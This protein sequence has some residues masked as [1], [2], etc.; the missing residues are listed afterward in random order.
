MRSKII[1]KA[2]NLFGR[3]GGFD[4]ICNLLEQASRGEITVTLPQIFSYVIFMYNTSPLWHRQFLCSFVDRLNNAILS[5]LS[6]VNTEANDS[7]KK[8]L[9]IGP[10]QVDTF[11][12]KMLEN[13]INIYVQPIW[14][15][16]NTKEM[17]NKILGYYQLE[18]GTALLKL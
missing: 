11:D 16:Y 5:S 3:R 2:L 17:D 10:C 13:M 12:Y 15:R 14:R 7:N 18:I 9:I 1:N 8:N 6:Y 4:Q